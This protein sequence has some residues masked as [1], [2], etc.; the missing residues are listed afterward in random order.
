M[1]ERGAIHWASEKGALTGKPRPVL[2]VQ[3]DRA[4]HHSTVTV[5]LVSTVTTPDAFF[6]VRIDPTPENGLDRVSN[7]QADRLF[8]LLDDSIDH[9]LGILSQS[10][11]R[12]VD[13]ALRRWLDL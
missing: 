2:I 1:I 4:R 9:R 10:D 11:Q 7:V 3:N 5:C 6:R 12:R 8:S 13:A